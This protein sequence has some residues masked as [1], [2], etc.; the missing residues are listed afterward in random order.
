MPPFCS[1]QWRT[2]STITNRAEPTFFFFFFYHFFFLF[3]PSYLKL[4][5]FLLPFPRG[6][7]LQAHVDGG[8]FVL[9][10]PFDY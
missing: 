8:V 6:G 9:S 7:N 5:F 3:F 1:R 10:Q 4:I 2:E